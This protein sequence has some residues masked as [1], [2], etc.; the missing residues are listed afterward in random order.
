MG[1]EQLR[2]NRLIKYIYEV[3]ISFAPIEVDACCIFLQKVP[4]NLVPCC[5]KLDIFANSMKMR[6]IDMQYPIPPKFLGVY[7]VNKEES[8]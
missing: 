1:T 5:T 2:R 3:Y 7:Q 8:L 4:F 6:K